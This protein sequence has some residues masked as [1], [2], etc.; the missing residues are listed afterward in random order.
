M[1]SGSIRFAR[2]PR[3]ALLLRVVIRINAHIAYK[4]LFDYT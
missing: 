4:V 1:G 2:R 3:L